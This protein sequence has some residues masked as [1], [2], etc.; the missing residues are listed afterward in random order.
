MI[1]NTTD[2]IGENT[3]ATQGQGPRMKLDQTFSAQHTQ[4]AKRTSHID[5]PN[6]G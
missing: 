2:K 5:G 6:I 4:R 3:K 1:Q